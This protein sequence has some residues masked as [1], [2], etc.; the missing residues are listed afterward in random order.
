METIHQ[1]DALITAFYHSKFSTRQEFKVDVDKTD[2]DVGL[3]LPHPLLCS[4]DELFYHRSRQR[5]G[6][7]QSGVILLPQTKI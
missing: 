7:M 6:R 4:S 2:I 5:E 1:K 3:A